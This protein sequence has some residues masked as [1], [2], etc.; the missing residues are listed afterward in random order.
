MDDRKCVNCEHANKKASN[1]WYCHKH[2][3]YITKNTSVYVMAPGGC[4][5]YKGD[6]E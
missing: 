4:K 6:K 3:V 5:D 2:R 1:L